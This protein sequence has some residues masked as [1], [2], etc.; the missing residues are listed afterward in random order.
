MKRGARVG[1]DERPNRC[2]EVSRQRFLGLAGVWGGPLALGRLVISR[3]RQSPARHAD[4]NPATRAKEFLRQF[5]YTP[6]FSF[7]YGGMRSAILLSRWTQAHQRKALDRNRT[8]HT[9][10]WAD[11]RTRLMVRCVAVEYHDFPIVE[12][13]LSF[14]NRE[15]QRC[16]PLSEVLAI[17][18]TFQRT[19]TTEFVLH[20]FD[21]SS[22]SQGDYQPYAQTLRPNAQ[23]LFSCQGGRPTN[24]TLPYFN[25]DWGGEGVIAAIGWPGQWTAQMTRDAGPGLRLRVGT[26]RRDPPRSARGHVARARRGDPHPADGDT[27]LAGTRLDRGP[28]R[29]AP[30]DDCLQHA[31]APHAPT[32]A[33]LSDRRCLRILCGPAGCRGRRGD[34]P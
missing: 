28:K 1:R 29:L 32:R 33:D 7:T 14:K 27:V 23:R 9:I 2:R 30:L 13:T 16:L 31:P 8:E 12:W 22:A 3:R 18:A 15:V 34:V 6:P 26:G 4:P 10:T 19:G 25:V 20:S 24:G 5:D 11:P 17:D 21:G